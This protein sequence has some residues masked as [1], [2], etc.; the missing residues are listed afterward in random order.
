MENVSGALRSAVTTPRQGP[1]A[2]GT[3]WTA[4]LAMASVMPVPDMIPVK[5]PAARISRTIGKALS[6]CAFSL[7]RWWIRHG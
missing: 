2:P 6:A 3:I 5:A 7:S 4:P 1:S